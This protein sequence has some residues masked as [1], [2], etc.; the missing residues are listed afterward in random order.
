M[1]VLEFLS[2][3]RKWT[4]GWC[5]RT[6]DDKMTCVCDAEAAKWCFVG[7]LLYCYGYGQSQIDIS[8]K[9]FE[10]LKETHPNLTNIATWNDAPERKH[11]EVLAL[12]KELG[13]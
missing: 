4:K 6:K 3:Q 12:C 2:D 1:T 10:K 8:K 7:A 13:I 5:A 11:S 9:V